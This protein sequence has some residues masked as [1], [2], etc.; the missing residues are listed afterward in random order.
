MLDARYATSERFASM[1]AEKW[2]AHLYDA[3]HAF[4]WQ[5]AKGVVELLSPQTGERILDLGCGTGA[6]AAEVASRGAEVMGVDRSI[7]MIDKARRKF[8]AIRFEVCDARKLPF[9]DEFNAVFSNAAL[10]WIPDAEPVVAGISRA[11]KNN[12]RFVAEFGGK[13]NVRQ[14]V[15]ALE[16][17]LEQLHIPADGANPWY[18]PSIAEYSALL[19]KHQLEVREA[20]LFVRPTKLEDSERG[21]ANWIKM[22]CGTYLERVPESDHENFL[23]AAENAAGAHLWKSDHWELDYRR[24]RLAAWKTVR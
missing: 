14:V 8:P 5:H 9:V 4:V 16:N 17:A 15:A 24:L 1:T 3:K 11:L 12:G 7:E 10:H 13:G 21:L 23:R 2:D 22:F 18:Y 19:E 6:L 20:A